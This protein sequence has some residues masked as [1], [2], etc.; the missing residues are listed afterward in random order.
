MKLLEQ[1]GSLETKTVYTC[2][3][4]PGNKRGWELQNYKKKKKR[5][6]MVPNYPS[7]VYISISHQAATYLYTIL[8]KKKIFFGRRDYYYYY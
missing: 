5:F 1:T 6:Y 7:Y 8:S 2:K 4:V 3:T